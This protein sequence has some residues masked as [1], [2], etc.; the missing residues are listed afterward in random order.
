VAESSSKSTPRTEQPKS[1]PSQEPLPTSSKRWEDSEEREIER[2]LSSHQDPETSP[3]IKSSKSPESSRP[4]VS[5]SP[6]P[7]RELLSRSSELVSQL[8]APLMERVLRRSL[9]RSIPESWFAPS[10]KLNILYNF[11]KMLRI[12]KSKNESERVFEKVK[13]LE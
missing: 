1:S 3:S 12:F 4:R 2:K 5:H 7:S 11:F 6:K 10:D 8:V 9:L 13:F